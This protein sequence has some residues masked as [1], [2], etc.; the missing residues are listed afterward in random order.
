MIYKIVAAIAKFGAGILCRID[1][2]AASLSWGLRKGY[3]KRKNLDRKCKIVQI[4]FAK[5]LCPCN[6]PMW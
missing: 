5:L 2:P 1:A 6:M 4:H 3:K